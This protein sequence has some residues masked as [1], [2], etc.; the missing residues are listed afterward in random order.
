MNDIIEME[1]RVNDIKWNGVWAIQ[2]K[3]DRAPLV[4]V[5]QEMV[6]LKEE[7]CFELLWNWKADNNK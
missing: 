5:R 3:P 1:W 6:C 7:L 2:I 4:A